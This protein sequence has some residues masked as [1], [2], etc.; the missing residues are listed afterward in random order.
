MKDK[1]KNIFSKKNVK[2]E[3]LKNNLEKNLFF[4]PTFII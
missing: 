3:E 4:F 2:I 1:F